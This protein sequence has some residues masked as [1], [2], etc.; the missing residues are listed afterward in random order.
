VRIQLTGKGLI[1]FVSDG[2]LHPFVEEQCCAHFVLTLGPLFEWDL[3]VQTFICLS[4]T[5]AV[6]PF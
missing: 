1:R 2:L 4:P 5:D 6:V 3:V